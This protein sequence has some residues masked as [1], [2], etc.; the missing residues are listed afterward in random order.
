MPKSTDRQNRRTR[1]ARNGLV[2]CRCKSSCLRFN[3]TTGKYE[4]P[5]EWIPPQRRAWHRTDDRLAA[6]LQPLQEPDAVQERLVPNVE[7]E[8]EDQWSNAREGRWVELMRHQLALVQELPATTLERPLKFAN[9]PKELGDYQLEYQEEDDSGILPRPN[10][11]LQALDPRNIANRRY[12]DQENT[13]WE[14]L[15]TLQTFQRTPDILQLR[16]DVLEALVSL[17]REKALQWETCRGGVVDGPYFNTEIFFKNTR[18]P[19][20]SIDAASILSLL[21]EK[22]KISKD[23][24]TLAS[25]FN[26]DPITSTYISCPECHC[27]YPYNPIGPDNNQLNCSFVKTPRSTSC[28]AALWVDVDRGPLGVV[29]KPIRK[30]VHQGL[31]PWLGRLLAR[32]EM[33][34]ILYDY[35]NTLLNCGGQREATDIWQGE[36]FRA[37]KDPSNRP[38][39]PAPAGEL[40]L[41]FS[42]S[43]DSFSPFQNKTAK[44]TASSTGMWM[45]LLNL[46]WHLRYLP[47]NMYLIGVIPGPKKPSNDE[48]NHYIRL[49][50][51]DLKELWTPGVFFS[52]TYTRPQGRLCQG[53]LIPLVCDLLAAHQVIGYPGAPTAHYFCTCCDLDIDDINVLNRQEWPAKDIRHIRRYAAIYRDSVSEEDQQAVFSACGWRWSPLFELEYWDPSLFTVIDSMHSLD[54]NLMQNHIRNLFQID[55]KNNAGEALRAPTQDR[56][57]R[58]AKD[59]NDIRELRRCQEKIFDNPPHLLYELLHYRRKVLYSFCLDYEILDPGHQLVVGTRWILAKNIYQWRQNPG[60]PSIQTFLTRYPNLSIFQEGLLNEPGDDVSGDEDDGA[61]SDPAAVTVVPPPAGPKLPKRPALRRL[62][63]KIIAS[64]NDNEARDAVYS[65]VTAVVIAHFCDIAQLDWSQIGQATAPLSARKRELF[66]FLV[67]QLEDDPVNQ[68]LLLGHFAEDDDTKSKQKSGA[69]LGKDVMT[70][71]WEDMDRTRLPN[72]ITPVPRDWGTIRRGKLSADN[73][74]IICCIHLPI[75]LIRLFGSA[76][77]RRRALLDNFMRLVSAARIATMRRSSQAQVDAYNSHILAHHAALHIGDIL[78]RF[79]PKHSHDS[80]HYERYIRFFHRMNTNNKIGEIEGTYLRSAVRNANILALLT[81]SQSVRE[82]VEKL[83]DRM[84]VHEKER[85]R[86]FRLAEALDPFNQEGENDNFESPEPDGQLAPLEFN[87]LCEVLQSSPEERNTPVSPRVTFVNAISYRNNVYAI[88]NSR[89]YR[90]SAVLY[91]ADGEER[92]GVIQT[93]FL[94]HHRFSSGQ[95]KRTRY[96]SVEEYKRTQNHDRYQVY[97]HAGG[98]LCDLG[99]RRFRLIQLDSVIAHVAVTEIPEEAMVH[100]L[101]ISRTL[102]SFEL[103]SYDVDENANGDP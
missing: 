76:E 2:L 35:P 82:L 84:R 53:L 7:T 16:L 67:T 6:L 40:R 94:H 85:L 81:D 99:A 22:D 60:S 23:P 33:E 52:R 14:M 57:K 12:L 64:L 51:N 43:V 54:L 24:R 59:P 80:P 58:V 55:L 92:A 8:A 66:N 47:Q 11:G 36:V 10:T 1:T 4:G 9:N 62:A 49:L 42:L 56:V 31:K 75:T 100:I 5:G 28:G 68:D 29:K 48:I 17:E 13:L 32:P 87:M 93:I 3:E 20:R 44:Q 18:S 102:L 89:R 70:A 83:L 71:I 101:P 72:W 27:L 15:R 34:S 50:V 91:K 73:W 96:L 74:R 90:D 95:T 79:G 30:Y 63:K 26:L 78:A 21:P 61:G 46:P 103:N 25:R 19:F 39:F 97:G 37:V 41:A 98:F 65:Q 86:G 38:F 77:G 45:V 88:W 69:F